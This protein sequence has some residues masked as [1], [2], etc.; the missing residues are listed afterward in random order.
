[1]KEKQMNWLMRI[2]LPNVQAI[3][4]YPFGIYYRNTP[5]YRI[6][7]HEKVHWAQQKEMLCLFFYLWYIIEWF[8]KLFFYGRKAYISISFEQEAR[9]FNSETR[10]HYG[11]LEYVF[12]GVIYKGGAVF[13]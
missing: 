10:K 11:W 7:Q 4:L 6:V 12:I 5:S 13:K 8:I 9:L 3:S 2:V 1:M